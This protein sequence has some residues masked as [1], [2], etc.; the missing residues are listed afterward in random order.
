MNS[1]NAGPEPFR[2][3]EIT[4]PSSTSWVEV[5]K[6]VD[7]KAIAPDGSSIHIRTSEF[8]TRGPSITIPKPKGVYRILCLGGNGVFSGELAEEQTIPGLLQ[9]YLDDAGTHAEVINA[10]CPQSGPLGH[11]LRYRTSLSAVQAD[12]VLL[13]ISIDDLALDTELRGALRLDEDRH[14]AYAAHPAALKSERIPTD[15]VRREFLCA[16]WLMDW[17]IHSFGSKTPPHPILIPQEGGYGRRELGPVASLSRMVS[18]DYG[19]LIVSTTPTAWGLEQTRSAITHQRPT[20][21]DDVR[22]TLVALQISDKVPVHDMTSDL[23][24][25]QD[26]R[27]L[28]SLRDGTMTAAGNE[29]YAQSLA[30]YL[31]QF[32]PELVP[33]STQATL[34]VPPLKTGRN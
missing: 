21:S 12:L 31:M 10:G 2:I 9:K 29:L 3:E 17:A 32:I 5:K 24:Q 1:V 19:R 8:G 26:P 23:C 20:F 27:S 18:A 7:R 13:C 15:V 25:M 4:I 14:P 33:A 22:K 11:T 34:P 6:L 30:R 28:F 16:T